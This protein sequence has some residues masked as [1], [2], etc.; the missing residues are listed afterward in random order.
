VRPAVRPCAAATFYMA[1]ENEP[2]ENEPKPKYVPP[3][4]S[5]FLS[6]KEKEPVV[7]I[8]SQ[9]AFGFVFLAFAL[10][11]FLPEEQLAVLRSFLP[12]PPAK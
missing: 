6:E 10:T 4:V 9:L 3:S 11:V 2:E 8:G 1:E 12:Q 5:P 7:V